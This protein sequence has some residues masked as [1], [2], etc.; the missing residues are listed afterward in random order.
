MQ[1]MLRLLSGA[2]HSGV[3]SAAAV[4][5]RFACASADVMADGKAAVHIPG[6][7]SVGNIAYIAVCASGSSPVWRAVAVQNP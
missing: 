1:T 6:L 2:S 4:D 5:T 3:I 7:K